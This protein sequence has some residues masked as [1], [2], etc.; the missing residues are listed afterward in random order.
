MGTELHKMGRAKSPP[1]IFVGSVVNGKMHK[2]KKNYKA[3]ANAF[4]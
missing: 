2:K 4:V 1:L 3:S